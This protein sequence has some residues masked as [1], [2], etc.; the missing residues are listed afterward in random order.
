MSHRDCA[1]LRRGQSVRA[2]LVGNLPTC[3]ILEHFD[4][5]VGVMIGLFDILLP[6]DSARLADSVPNSAVAQFAHFTCIRPRPTPAPACHASH[7]SRRVTAF[8]SFV[9]VASISLTCYLSRPIVST[10]VILQK[11]RDSEPGAYELQHSR[12]PNPMQSA[13]PLALCN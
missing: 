1:M 12:N 6:L 10:R 8:V 3:L 4:R 5:N 2:L 9:C 13:L 11:S 7:P